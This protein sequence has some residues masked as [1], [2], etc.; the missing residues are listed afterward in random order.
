MEG[1]LSGVGFNVGKSDA[2]VVSSGN[3]ARRNKGAN[4]ERKWVFP[5]LA[6]ND[7][8]WWILPGVTM[9]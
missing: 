6:D 9:Q 3:H 2:R 4:T 5:Q 7:V 1:V 8:A